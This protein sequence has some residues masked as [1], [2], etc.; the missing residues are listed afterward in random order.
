M[1]GVEDAFPVEAGRTELELG[2]LYSTAARAFDDGGDTFRRDDNATHV[3]GFTAKYG[4]TSFLDAGIGIFGAYSQDDD[5]PERSVTGLGDLFVNAKWRFYGEGDD[6][7]HLAYQPDLSIPVGKHDDDKN[8]SPGLG[9]WTFDQRLVATLIE[10]RWVG[11]VSASF[12]LPFGDRNGARGFASA[13]LGLGYQ[14]MPW[15][16]PELELNYVR[17]FSTGQKDAETVAATVG[18]IVNLSDALRADLGFRHDFYGRNADRR[19]SVTAS[20]LWTF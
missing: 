17:E 16:K 8:L 15:L 14:L 3:G 1:V 5:E 20:F 4:F 9:F 13:D 7:L 10:R 2:Y 12:F 18:A 11:G 6:G 19:L